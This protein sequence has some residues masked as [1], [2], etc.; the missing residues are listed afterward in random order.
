VNGV[1]PPSGLTDVDRADG[2]LENDTGVFLQSMCPTFAVKSRRIMRPA[3]LRITFTV[4][5][6]LLCP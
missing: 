2:F 3:V 6:H 1:G 4:S 5:P